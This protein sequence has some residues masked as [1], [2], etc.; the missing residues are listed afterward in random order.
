MRDLHLRREYHFY[1]YIMGSRSLNFYVGMCNNIERRV[2]EHKEGEIEGFTERYNINRLLYYEH[3]QYVF[4]AIHRE[5]QLKTW[6]R[7]K[8]L[9]LI[10][11]VNPT[12][13]DLSEEW[14]KS[15]SPLPRSGCNPERAEPPREMQ[16][17]H[18]VR[19]DKEKGK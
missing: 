17:P 15:I 16:I 2:R 19:A 8:K 5:K 9:A 14:G 12:L 1:V 3:H 4:N 18:F 10:R 7:A 13:L 11:S 6:S